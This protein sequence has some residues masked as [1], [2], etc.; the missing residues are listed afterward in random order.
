LRDDFGLSSFGN[1]NKKEK[2]SK[3]KKAKSSSFSLG[4]DFGFKPLGGLDFGFSKPVGKEPQIDAAPKSKV[5]SNDFG[6]IGLGG[7]FSSNTKLKAPKLPKMPQRKINNTAKLE[8]KLKQQAA[9]NKIKAKYG[10]KTPKG[11]AVAP[12]APTLSQRIKQFQNK[13]YEEGL[14]KKAGIPKDFEANIAAEKE[15]AQVEARTAQAAE[16]YARSNEVYDSTTNK[17]KSKVLDSNKLDKLKARIKNQKK[18]RYTFTITKEGDSK[19]ITEKTLQDAERVAGGYRSMGY[20]VSPIQ[21]I[22]L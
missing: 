21:Q 5:P 2:K 22:F 20:A 19:S 13:R 4:N 6:M 12:Q 14:R 16:R 15:K 8:N 7:M 3:T 17:Y 11:S 1:D 9:E 10:I 18:V